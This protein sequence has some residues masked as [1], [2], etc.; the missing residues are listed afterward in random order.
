MFFGSRIR[1]APRHDQSLMW[2]SPK[3]SHC[4][5]MLWK[6]P[7]VQYLSVW[8][9]ATCNTYDYTETLYLAY[10]AS[11]SSSGE[12]KPAQWRDSGWRDD[13]QWVMFGVMRREGY[14]H[15]WWDHVYSYSGLALLVTS[16]CLLSS[17]ITV[18]VC[19]VTQA[20]PGLLAAAAA[21]TAVTAVTAGWRDS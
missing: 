7:N 19:G 3:N 9:P 20:W 1:A 12:I 10:N 4:Y 2:F 13:S 21:V 14:F 8:R 17:L 15:P 5:C 18:T 11:S 6:C 16:K